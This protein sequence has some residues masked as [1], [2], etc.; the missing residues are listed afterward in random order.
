MYYYYLVKAI[1]RHDF[2]LRVKECDVTDVRA[3]ELAEAYIG[4]PN[5]NIREAT[6]EDIFG[7]EHNV[8]DL[9]PVIV[10]LT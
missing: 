8:V 1:G 9:T 10:A 2:L 5:F 6:I 3:A 7:F 4:S